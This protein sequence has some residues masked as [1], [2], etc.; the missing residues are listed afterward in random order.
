MK[1]SKVRFAF[2]VALAFVT[3]V[4][5]QFKPGGYERFIKRM[6]QRF[7][8]GT[9][10][11]KESIFEGTWQCTGRIYRFNIDGTM[12][13]TNPEGESVNGQWVHEA[14]AKGEPQTAIY[15]VKDYATAIWIE[16]ETLFIDGGDTWTELKRI[17]KN[18]KEAKV[19]NPKNN[20][21]QAGTGQPATRPESKSE[22]GDKPQP[23]SKGRSR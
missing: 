6:Q 4:Q 14:I 12:T 7:D 11:T 5:A 19:T 18:A 10:P 23:E 2:L 20:A 3:T 8:H 9:K 17:A 21:E 16:G 22:G 1:W 15:R 13:I